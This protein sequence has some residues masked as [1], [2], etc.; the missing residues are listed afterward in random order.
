[1]LKEELTMDRE[2]LSPPPAASK[3]GPDE[4]EAAVAG[5]RD[6]EILLLFA[7]LVVRLETP[8]ERP[9]PLMSLSMVLGLLL[10][11]RGRADVE[12]VWG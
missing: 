7:P 8:V 11:L 9:M 5:I 4:P 12:R 10:L 6:C 3:P 1:M 2:G